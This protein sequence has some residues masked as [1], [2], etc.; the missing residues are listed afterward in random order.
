MLWRRRRDRKRENLSSG[1]GPEQSCSNKRID[2]FILRLEG[3]Y[4]ST[5][6]SVHILELWIHAGVV[7]VSRCMLRKLLLNHCHFHGKLRR[8]PTWRSFPC[9]DGCWNECDVQAATHHQGTHEREVLAGAR[10]QLTALWWY[11][12]SWLL[13]TAWKALYPF[14]HEQHARLIACN[15]ECV[16]PLDKHKGM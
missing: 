15:S 8:E 7:L 1:E 9:R 10:K 4:G 13:S 12:S 16:D 11:F 6:E 14:V 3:V 5:Y 2:S